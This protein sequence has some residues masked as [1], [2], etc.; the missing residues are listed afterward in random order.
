MQLFAQNS[1]DA[2]K[3]GIADGSDV[4]SG[5]KVAQISLDENAGHSGTGT[6]HSD[7]KTSERKIVIDD[8][9]AF[10]ASLPVGPGVKAAR[11]LS[12]FA[13]NGPKL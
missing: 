2:K 11:P 8:V 3:E 10:R 12:D 4:V 9:R 1:T 5:E 6:G 7:D 13:E